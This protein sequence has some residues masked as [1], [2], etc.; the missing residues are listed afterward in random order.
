MQ[1]EQLKELLYKMY[2]VAYRIQDLL[3]QERPEKWKAPDVERASFSQARETLRAKLAEFEKSRSQLAASPESGELAFQTYR[4]LGALQGPLA[5][6]SRSVP[7]NQNARLADEFQQ[8][9]RELT[10]GQQSLVPYISYF[11]DHWDRAVHMFQSNLAACQNQLNYAMH[12][13]VQAATPLPNVNPEF[14]GYRRQAPSHKETGTAPVKKTGLRK[15][16]KP[17]AK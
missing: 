17:S 15:S 16:A 2:A 13:R 10:A 12:S 7:V 3:N 5:Q 11:L 1:P 6:V 4:A 8:R 14:R 9:G